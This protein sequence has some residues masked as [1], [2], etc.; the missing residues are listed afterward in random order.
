MLGCFVRC[1]CEFVG[2]SMF[3]DCWILCDLCLVMVTYSCLLVWGFSTGHFDGFG[4]G[5]YPIAFI[6]FHC[7]ASFGWFCLCFIGVILVCLDLVDIVWLVLGL[8]RLCFARSFL[9][10]VRLCLCCTG[11]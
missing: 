8:D 6:S 1:V 5:V 4:V 11:L 7:S 10:H 9:G 2:V 3:I